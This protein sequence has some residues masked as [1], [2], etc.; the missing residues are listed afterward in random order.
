MDCSCDTCKQMCMHPC[1]PTPQEAQKL[2]DTGFGGKMMADYWI[3]DYGNIYILCPASKGY[4]GK[5]APFNV[6]GKCELQDGYGMCAL[7]DLGLKPLEGV[8]AMHDVPNREIHEEIAM[9]WNNNLG[10]EMVAQ[11]RKQWIS[12]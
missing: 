8:M 1:W 11:W 2:I 9:M 10:E 12:Q 5:T 4:G 3:G 6:W 7:H